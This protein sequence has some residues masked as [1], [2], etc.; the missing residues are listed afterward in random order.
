MADFEIVPPTAE[1]AP[2][3]T[4][5][6]PA[7]ADAPQ[8][9]A[10]PAFEVESP[11]TP[12]GSGSRIWD[13][14]TR[15]VGRGGELPPDQQIT[16]GSPLIGAAAGV[17]RDI[18]KDALAGVENVYEGA[19]RLVSPSRREL[20]PDAGLWENLKADI[21]DMAAVGQIPLGVLQT[22]GSPVTGGVKGTLGDAMSMLP[23]YSKEKADE[24]I[25]TALMGARPGRGPG[26]ARPVAPEPLPAGEAAP[27]PR[28][29]W[30]RPV[31]PAPRFET[32][33]PPKAGSEAPA[34]PPVPDPAPG[35][36]RMYHGGV[37]PDGGP[38]WV[39]PSLADA[40]GW[41]AR[42]KDMG[43]YYVDVPN[44]H[45]AM[46][47]MSGF[48]A[49][50]HEWAGSKPTYGR[51]ELPADLAKDL[52][53]YRPGEAAG[54]PS[55][56]VGPDTEVRI[57]DSAARNREGLDAL[58][59]GEK[60]DIRI[61]DSA[62]QPRDFTIEPPPEAAAAERPASPKF[63][64]AADIEALVRDA[65][66]VSEG[67]RGANRG[68]QSWEE[69]QALADQMGLTTEEMLKWRKGE[70][71]NAEQGKARRDLLAQ[72]STDLIETAR[73]GRGG[74]DA[75][76]VAF[77]EKFLENGALQQVMIGARA[78]SGRALNALKM[79]TKLARDKE[80]ALQQIVKEY[81][82]GRMSVDQLM[83]MVASLDD[84]AKVNAFV[85]EAVKAKTMDKVME[86]W[87]NG[88]L[89]GPQTH[90]VNVTSNLLTALWTVPE[91]A[92]AAGIGKLHGGER[93]FG[94]EIGRRAYGMV[95][96]AIDGWRAGTRA[97]KTGEAGDLV[98]QVE[99][100]RNAI[101]GKLGEVV[102]VPSRALTAEDEFFKAMAYRSEIAG[103]AVRTA[104]VEGLKG[105]AFAARVAEL[106]ANPTQAMK[107][108]AGNQ[109][110][111]LTFQKD[112]GTFGQWV[113]GLA[114]AN[115]AM[116][117]VLPF[118]R[119]PSNIIKMAVERTPA[120]VAMREV[121]ADLLGKNG[122]I[123]R[124]Q[125]AA[126]MALGTSLMIAT[127][128]LAASGYIT[129]GGPSDPELKAAL[130]NT[131]WQ[132]YSVKL[133]DTYYAYNRFAPLGMVLGLA[134]DMQDV[135][136]HADEKE[137]DK[138][139][140]MM[141]TSASKNLVSQSFLKG[142]TDL[143][144]AIADPDRYAQPWLNSQA[145][146]LVPS[147]VGQTTAS[148]DP[149]MRETRSMLDAMKA[150]VPGLSETL[151]PKRNIWG[152]PIERPERLGPD[153]V[154]PIQMRTDKKDKASNEVVR[155]KLEPKPID[156]K[157]N[158][159]ELSPQLYDKMSKLSGERAKELV[160]QMVNSPGWDAL[161][162]FQQIKYIRGALENGR[163]QARNQ[164]IGEHPELKEKVD[165][166]KAR[167]QLD[168]LNKRPIKVE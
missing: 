85:R 32:V 72:S 148:V 149:L 57:V 50:E 117:V 162:A 82:S 160:D 133:G 41:A 109:A 8:Q 155:L 35:F 105:E 120:G 125:A 115:P 151:P 98:K 6:P 93:V 140:A 141:V 157:I 69:T 123:A 11:A 66:R 51:T 129:G 38:R 161:P 77:L 25:D 91:T 26:A 99:V 104:R 116:R 167:K 75:Q 17:V 36:T 166:S 18:G 97:F 121:R 16:L 84:P 46:R 137:L 165:E 80:K 78:E 49:A 96:G 24:A 58:Q 29:A 42:S 59:R 122:N 5:E 54:E 9:A 101:P 37:A 20:P 124:D 119:T 127:G 152:Q 7:R 154:S 28:A 153:I 79:Q 22:L 150:R 103:Q 52:K 74:T 89:S 142:P 15:I 34:A 100:N 163:A 1:P 114:A 146:S 30:E 107:D 14:V 90:A 70:A 145:G 88:L 102:R 4:V 53:P 67:A 158:G 131:G 45:P 86:A 164:M 23:G 108:A 126:R 33:V 21:Q 63:E 2:A 55:S 48:T 144:K 39:T 27:P 92:L 136:D 83:D 44:A 13:I 31:E 81:E 135:R 95:Q 147:I 110:R 118:V 62:L 64:S 43:V 159:V 87:I 138:L 156:R 68:V 76:K 168:P 12:E 61:T 40:E 113:M 139:G 132:P 128:A 71:F 60:V 94:S 3:F 130:M 10:A 73:A 47:D 56:I 143:I 134:A 19:K 112:L 111:Y 65:D 106:E